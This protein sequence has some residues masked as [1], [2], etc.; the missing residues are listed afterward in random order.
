MKQ[1]ECT[2]FVEPTAKGR[3]RVT[4]IGGHAHAYTPKR[5]RVAEA[6]IKAAIRKEVMAL[7][8]FDPGVPLKVSATFYIEKPKSSPKKLVMPVKRPD[9]ANY[10]ALLCDA[11]QKFVYHDD[12]EIV[13]ANIRK[14]FGS[15]PRIE[16]RI[17]EE[18]E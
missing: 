18:V 5:T 10:F 3:P 9:L 4:T 17:T 13:T 2:I 8:D 7:G 11:L 16:L 12:S 6:D 1:I 15:P 14:R